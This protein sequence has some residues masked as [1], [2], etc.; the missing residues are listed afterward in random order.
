MQNVSIE[1]NKTVASKRVK[2][3]KRHTYCILYIYR[4]SRLN[5]SKVTSKLIMAHNKIFRFGSKK[6]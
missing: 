6:K 2:G 5:R 4:E 1:K 3:Q